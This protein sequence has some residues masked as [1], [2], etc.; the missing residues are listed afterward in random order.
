MHGPILYKTY[1]RVTVPRLCHSKIFRVVLRYSSSIRSSTVQYAIVVE[2][3]TAGIPYR[4][5]TQLVVV[6]LPTRKYRKLLFGAIVSPCELSSFV[7][8]FPM[9]TTS[10][11][12][13]DGVFSRVWGAICSQSSF[14]PAT[15]CV[16]QSSSKLLDQALVH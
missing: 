13:T 5:Q 4:T 10:V 1:I 12:I 14:V 7:C 9:A 8:T 16:V 3:S 2:S 6:S 11:G 15:W